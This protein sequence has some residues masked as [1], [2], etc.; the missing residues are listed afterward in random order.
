[1]TVT[2]LASTYVNVLKGRVQALAAAEARARQRGEQCLRR[3]VAF[4]SDR[5]HRP[6]DQAKRFTPVSYWIAAATVVR[7]DP[8][9]LLKIDDKGGR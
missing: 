7:C 9:L 4:T 6:G 3:A 8:R 1:M 5:C 2:D